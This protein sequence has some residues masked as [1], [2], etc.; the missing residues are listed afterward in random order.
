MTRQPSGEGRASRE[1]K[2]LRRML[3]IRLQRG[4]ALE[5]PLRSAWKAYFGVEFFAFWVVL[6]YGAIMSDRA[7]RDACHF[8]SY[9]IGAL[10]VYGGLAATLAIRRK[11]NAGEYPGKA[12]LSQRHDYEVRLTGAVL[13]SARRKRQPYLLVDGVPFPLK[14][15]LFTSG[16]SRL[17]ALQVLR[18]YLTGD[19]SCALPPQRNT[20]VFLAILDVI[21]IQGETVHFHAIWS[22]FSTVVFIADA[23]IPSALLVA[24]MAAVPSSL[25]SATAFDANLAVGLLIN[26]GIAIYLRR[27]K[28]RIAITAGKWAEIVEHGE[29]FRCPPWQAR[30]VVTRPDPM[31]GD[32]S[33]GQIYPYIELKYGERSLTVHSSRMYDADELEEFVDRMNHFLWDSPTQP[34]DPARTT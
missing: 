19:S 11:V 28:P 25:H 12:T 14:P 27:C 5:I 10:L 4:G 24:M 15:R 30:F 29:S 32:D 23:L 17:A 31:P 13:G 1:Q 7:M 3:S 9:L 26:F 2:L 20:S 22:S 18:S 8:G 16:A 6:P 34:A 33:V 21:S